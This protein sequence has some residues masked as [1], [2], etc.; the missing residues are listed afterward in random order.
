MEGFNSDD[1]IKIMQNKEKTEVDKKHD[2]IFKKILSIK[3]EAVMY[4]KRV[5][6][7]ELSK[8]DIEVYDK[9]FIGEGGKRLEADI[10]YKVK[11]KKLF[12]LVE[13]QTKRDFKI[14]LRIVKYDV[15]IMKK[16]SAKKKGEKEALVLASVIHTGEGK[17]D[18]ATNIR[19]AQEE[20]K[21][22][23]KI[24]K[25]EIG[26]LGSYELLDI[27]EYT[28]EELLEGD[29]LLDKVMY[30][31]KLK[32]TKELLEG[33]REIFKRI[34]KKYY[35]I[36]SEVIRILLSGNIANKKIEELIKKLK[37][38]KSDMLAIKERIDAE[39]R[40]YREQGL[41]DGR[42]AGLRDGEKEIIKRLINN[43]YKINEI[44][45]MVN[46]TEEEI[47]KIIK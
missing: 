4:I 9:E 26:T 28:K 7:I 3:E 5:Y 12:L 29:S 23:L 34:D 47:K 11:D 36:M 42:K 1:S 16:V 2:K 17:W 37:G 45:N 32:G 46:L 20:I 27:N 24:P 15:E 44:S 18:V 10:V 8:E 6:N 13:H 19:E 35:G 41:R 43:G 39:F 14:P 22:N 25:V 33:T 40:G 38:G 30:L 21:E 31:E